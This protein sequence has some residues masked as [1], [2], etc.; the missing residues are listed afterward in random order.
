KNGFFII[1]SNTKSV[2]R[3][4][5]IEPY[6]FMKRFSNMIKKLFPILI[7]TP[8]ADLSAW[9]K[10]ELDYGIL[11][12]SSQIFIEKGLPVLYLSKI[13]ILAGDDQQMKP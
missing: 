5:I 10:S 13:K 11:D 9:N 3:L 4:A 1:Y 2:A 6:K 12:V 7:V 8:E